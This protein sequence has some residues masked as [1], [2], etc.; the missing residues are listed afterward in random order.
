MTKNVLSYTV[1]MNGMNKAIVSVVSSIALVYSGLCFFLTLSNYLDTG[2]FH[3]FLFMPLVFDGLG[4]D[5]TEFL[6]QYMVGL[7]GSALYE[8]LMEFIMGLLPESMAPYHLYIGLALLLSGFILAVVGFIAKPSLDCE[9]RTNPAQY[10]WTHRP[11]AYARCL[12]MPWGILVG[13]WAR[14][15]PL[16]IVPILL[17][18]LYAF[19]SVFIML[20]LILPFGIAKLVVG[21]KI[22]SAAKR[23][24]ASYSS[25]TDHGVCP[26]CKRNFDRPVV[27]CRCGLKLDYPVPN[28]YGYRYHTCNKGHD[29]PCESG[30]RTNLTTICPHCGEQIYTREALPVTI[31]LVG[32]TSTG[33]TSLMLA[34]VDTIARNARLV[35]ITVD[36]PSTGLSR[37]A[38]AAKDFAPRTVPGELESQILFLRSHRLQDKE[39]VFNDI[40]GVEFQPAVDKVL[41]EEYYNYTNGIIFT[42]DPMSFTRELKRE[43]PHEVFECFHNMYATIRNIGPGVVSDVPFAIVATKSDVSNPQLKDEDVRQY[44]I[45]NGEEDFVRVAE[46]L[47]SNIRYFSVCSHGRDCSSAMRP[48][49][50]IVGT[51]DSKL[52]EL[53][54]SP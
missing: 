10:L 14:S 34:A 5:L 21:F 40:S 16:V 53:I 13:A 2:E 30:K 41:F 43:T 27:K 17:L 24:S 4:L 54:P 20:F 42:F 44:L 25:N 15:K 39:I 38:L 49:W 1:R 46:S 11:H 22:K 47:F 50:W 37:E 31:S 33:K 45:D 18:P 6:T 12:L 48:V 8:R 52:V 36:S 23:E 32:G 29:I 26:H 9:G 28:I 3:F 51:V 19:W 7:G 35:D